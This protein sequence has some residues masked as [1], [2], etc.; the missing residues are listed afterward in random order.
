MQKINNLS[1]DGF[2][3]VILEIASKGIIPVA[4]SY[5]L[6][7]VS[8]QHTLEQHY[9]K[10]QKEF[11]S[12]RKMLPNSCSM[13][14]VKYATID[15]EYIPPAYLMATLNA[16]LSAFV[17][18][19]AMAVNGMGGDMLNIENLQ[20]FI[21]DITNQAQSECE[22][23]V[24]CAENAH[25]VCHIVSLMSSFSITLLQSLSTLLGVRYQDTKHYD[26]QTDKNLC[27]LISCSNEFT[28]DLT[29]APAPA[30]NI[31]AV[32]Q[33]KR[34]G[35]VISQ[36]EIA[37]MTHASIGSINETLRLIEKALADCKV[38]SAVDAA[39]SAGVD[40]DAYI[41]NDKP[42]NADADCWYTEEEAKQFLN[43]S[44]LL[45]LPEKYQPDCVVHN[46]KRYWNEDEL[47]RVSDMM[48]ADKCLCGA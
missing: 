37:D 12:E 48:E 1:N 23:E 38:A 16:L 3:A 25:K 15:P 46:G 27:G 8:L 29:G 10:L 4:E 20:T 47:V 40:I 7:V 43:I 14:W 31:T 42:V 32:R 30:H 34:H 2:T 5:N 17:I 41:T 21:D 18:G 28:G 11:V 35:N 44:N 22:N 36:R 26:L 45:S 6:D 19:A 13:S 9:N 24:G 33:I 39:R